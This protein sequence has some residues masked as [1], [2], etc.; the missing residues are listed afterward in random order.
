MSIL[1]CCVGHLPNYHHY[2]TSSAIPTASETTRPSRMNDQHS[3]NVQVLSICKLVAQLLRI[4]KGTM[5]CARLASP[6]VVELS[7]HLI[8]IT[9]SGRRS[10]SEDYSWLS[11]GKVVLGL[12]SSKTTTA[13]VYMR[14]SVI[15]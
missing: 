7:K 12:F 5:R 9:S 1:T 3:S 13:P 14:M 10:L 15:T 11:L 8:K 2:D 6:G 4:H